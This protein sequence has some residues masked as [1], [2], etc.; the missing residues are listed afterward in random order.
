[1]SLHVH[2]HVNFNELE[3]LPERLEGFWRRVNSSGLNLQA[4]VEPTSA[5]RAADVLTQPTAVTTTTGGARNSNIDNN[6]AT[7][8]VFDVN[9]AETLSS[10]GANT[11]TQSDEA[12]EGWEAGGFD[13]I[14]LVIT[15]TERLTVFFQVFQGDFSFLINHR[16][17]LV[18]MMTRCLQPT[19]R[20]MS[21]TPEERR[22]RFSQ[23][24]ASQT[25]CQLRW[26][27]DLTQLIEEQRR[28]QVDFYSDLQKYL[29]FVHE[30][31][32][33][34]ILNTALDDNAWVRALE[35][36]VV[37]AV[38]IFMNR[39]PT[40]FNNET[41]A[42]NLITRVLEHSVRNL[43]ARQPQNAEQCLAGLRFAVP[44]ML[45]RWSN[46][47]R[48]RHQREGD[49]AIFADPRASPESGDDLLDDCLDE[50]C[51]D[52]TR[53]VVGRTHGDDGLRDALDEF[54]GLPEDV[55]E[56]IRQ[57]AQRFRR[58]GPPTEGSG[59]AAGSTMWSCLRN[60][61]EGEK[62]RRR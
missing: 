12:L 53:P 45:T 37:R 18:G 28:P 10:T 11:L 60:S 24:I 23:R 5:S 42:A 27:S 22:R 14:L 6:N 50:F 40:W 41:M 38:G 30:E 3:E 13:D 49:A 54:R 32:V 7:D 17:R 51:A 34:S 16:Q 39:A 20:T 36:T 52:P 44:M 15:E 8:A 33:S 26:Q 2:I 55:A 19:E 56:G 31:V 9:L 59:G 29:A 61:E 43:W 4:H 47:Y 35:A 46:D 62:R 1:M 58:E 57:R 48:A 21:L 25:L